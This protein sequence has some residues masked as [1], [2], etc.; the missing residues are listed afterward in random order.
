M[1]LLPAWKEHFF[2]FEIFRPEFKYPLTPIYEELIDCVLN[3]EVVDYDRLVNRLRN[4]ISYEAKHNQCG[5]QYTEQTC[6]EAVEEDCM[7]LD[8]WMNEYLVEALFE[9]IM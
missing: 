4:A 7:Q 1:E 3:E 8:E 6:A 2:S 9:A 5:L